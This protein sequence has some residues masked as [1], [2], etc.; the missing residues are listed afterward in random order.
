LTTEDVIKNFSSVPVNNQ[1]TERIDV[2][3]SFY[4]E[5]AINLNNLL[6]EGRLK[7]IAMTKLEESCMI[8]IKAISHK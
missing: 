3:R 8:A 5:M 4:Q 6:P 1:Q 2:T 7:S